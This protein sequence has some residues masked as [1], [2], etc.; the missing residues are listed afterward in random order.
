VD[1]FVVRSIVVPA[2]TWLLGDRAWW[3]STA[4]AGRRSTLVS[5]VYTTRELLGV[6]AEGT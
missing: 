2:L 4:P 5:G 6:D 1:T 3:P